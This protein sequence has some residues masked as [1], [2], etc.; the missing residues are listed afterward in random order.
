M[1]KRIALSLALIANVNM[2]AFA[3]ESYGLKKVEVTQEGSLK[4]PMQNEAFSAPETSKLTIDK[5]T[6]EEIKIANPKNVFEA[7]NMTAGANIQFQGRKNSAIITFRG[8][9]NIYSAAAFGVILDGALLAPMSSLRMM[10]SLSMDV[11]ESIE[12]IR[13]ASALTLGP[14]AGFGTPNGSP[15]LGY[16]V[17]KTKLPKRDGGSAKFAYESFNTKIADISYGG[18]NDKI[19]YLASLSGYFTDGRDNFNT[20]QE[21][22][23]VFVRSGY[24]DEGFSATISAYYSN[25][26]KETQK[27]TD[28]LSKVTSSEWKYEPMEN[29]FISAILEKDFNQNN[30][31]T[32]Q[33][34]HTKTT[35][36]QDYDRTNPS[37][38]PPYYFKGEQSTD[39]I[40]LRHAIK[41]NNT[42]VKVGVQAMFYNAPDGELFYEGYERKEQI[43]GTFIH[44]SHSFDNNRLTIDESF[45]VDRKHIDSSI[46]RYD[47]NSV[48]AGNVTKLNNAELSIIEDQWAK[49]S[50]AL[51]LGAIY[52]FDDNLEGSAR[53]AYLTSGTP[54]DALSA[55][56]SDMKDE[57]SYRYEAGLKK[58]INEY[59]NPTLNLFLYD[60]KNIKSPIYLGTNTDPYIVFNQIDQKRYGGELG[61]EGTD[62]ELYYSFSYAYAT[63]DVKNNEIPKHTVSA[64]L[65]KKIGD[66]AL[67][68]SGK[69]LSAYESNFF[70][71]DKKYHD[72]GDFISINLSLDYNHKLLGNDAKLSIYSRNLT[73]DNYVTIF[74]FENQGRVIGAS[75]EFKF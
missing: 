22:G 18:I 63:A 40:D 23:S 59:F 2:Y 57:E 48:L 53:F 67:N 38:L 26:D 10:E 20:A 11:I 45:R 1:N 35:W 24:I 50:I 21:R 25:A 12:V 60:N 65:Q 8:S 51:S 66:Y 69:Y 54:D 3:N 36:S 9:P 68:F 34:S 42:L 15:T 39:S 52:K 72:I 62:K 13:D 5:L 64:I 28:P 37:Q 33:L 55:D 58:R 56:G 7:I 4:A 32:L 14:I 27:A 46:E 16:I 61:F 71:I 43:Y 29:E 19:F 47:P 49:S 17:I 41:L 73:D 70:T 31:T 74:G 75:Y 30:K 6:E 44:A